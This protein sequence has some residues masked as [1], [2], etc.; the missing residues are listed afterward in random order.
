MTLL[1]YCMGGVFCLMYVA[2]H[3]DRDVRN[4]V[5]IATPVDMSKMGLLA[6]VAKLAGRQV[7]LLARQMG[8]VPGGLSSTAFRLLT[9][10]KN[11]TRYTDLFLNLWNHE[12]V[13]GFEAMNQWIK[14]F[15][16]YPRDAFVQF[17]RDFMQQNKLARGQ[18]TLG[19]RVV[20]L[21]DVKSALLVFAGKSD[22]V[23]PPA[24]VRALMNKVGSK[25]KTFILVPAGHMGILAGAHAPSQVWQPMARWLEVRSQPTTRLSRVQR[26]AAAQTASPSSR[27]HVRQRAAA[28]K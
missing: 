13:L 11:L 24:S 12:Y 15:I 25:D 4:L 6:W 2:A 5:C 7:E 8:N 23:A 9:P 1:G 16:D 17:T 22:Q 3:R 27:K 10:M 18:L 26:Q 19:G 14:Q 20:H 21:R 28:G